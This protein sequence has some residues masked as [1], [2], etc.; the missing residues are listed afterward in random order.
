MSKKLAILLTHGMG[1][2][3]KDE[4]EDK[5]DE[6]A[7]AVEKELGNNFSKI[8]FKPIYFQD[9]LQDNQNK[10]FKEIK[11][12]SEIDWIK[13][14]K[15]MLFSFSDATSLEHRAHQD[16]SVYYQSQE[17]VFNTLIAAYNELDNNSKNAIVVAH[18]LGCQVISNYIWDS[19]SQIP[20]QGIWT[21]NHDATVPP[22]SDLEKFVRMKGLKALFTTGCNIPIFVAGRNK[23]QAVH[24]SR[25][26]YSF[27]WHNFYDEDDVLGWPM[28]PL[29]KF[30]DPQGGGDTYYNTITQDHEINAN[31]SFFS[32]LTKSWNPLGL[33]PAP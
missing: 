19:Q 21:V 32:A 20:I 33:L 30:H 5:V 12:E 6:L 24:S 13:I 28:K 8:F 16:N 7:S 26:G 25:N 3:S 23:I 11:K 18:S 4:F 29:G 2:I 27:E 22:G 31:S 1:T 14:R 9:I 10:V 17:R 15:F